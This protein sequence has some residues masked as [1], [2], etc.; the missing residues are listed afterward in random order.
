MRFT[1]KGF[2]AVVVVA[3]GVV[4]APAQ[5][6]DYGFAGG[7]TVDTS[8]VYATDSYGTGSYGTGSYGTGSYGTG[9]YGTGGAGNG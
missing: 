3:A 4:A 2:A 9:S 8:T 6:D 5:A 1:K 7:Y